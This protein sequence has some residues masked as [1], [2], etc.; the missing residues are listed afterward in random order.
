M[1]VAVGALITYFILLGRG[2]GEGAAGYVI[3]KGV[4]HGS[5]VAGRKRTL[6]KNV[7]DISYVHLMELVLSSICTIAF[8]YIIS[9]Y[10]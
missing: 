9:R 6:V 2:N 10:R 8:L 4:Y 3:C 5:R 1:G 7:G